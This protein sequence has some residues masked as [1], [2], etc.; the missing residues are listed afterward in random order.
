MR[1]SVREVSKRIDLV[2]N[3]LPLDPHLRQMLLLP[4]RADRLDIR[5][6]II[7]GIPLR[8]RTL[9]VK[10]ILDDHQIKIIVGRRRL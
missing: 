3:S 10:I 4:P 7:D 2:A 5:F 9:P 1:P 8:M 6:N